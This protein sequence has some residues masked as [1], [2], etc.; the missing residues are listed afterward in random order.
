MAEDPSEIFFCVFFVKTGAPTGMKKGKSAKRKNI[1]A[2]GTLRAAGPG[3]AER[4][5]K[6]EPR[7]NNSQEAHHEH[8][9]ETLPRG[10]L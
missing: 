1:D 4:P 5:K 6:H 9:S 7:E 2:E 10:A 8:A 3:G